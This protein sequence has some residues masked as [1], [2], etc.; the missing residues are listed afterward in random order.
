L[1]EATEL[2]EKEKIPGIDDQ[3][4]ASYSFLGRLCVLCGLCERHRLFLSPAALE[5]AEFTGKERISS[6]YET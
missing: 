1:L 3:V 2:T 5:D 6:K 4:L